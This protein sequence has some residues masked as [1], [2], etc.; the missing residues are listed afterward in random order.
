MLIRLVLVF[1][2]VLFPCGFLSLNAQEAFFDPTKDLLIAQFDCK[3]DVDDLHTVAALATLLNHKEYKDIHYH[4]VAGAYGIQ[5]GLYVLPNALFQLAF[6]THWSDAHEDGNK[7]TQEVLSLVEAQLDSGGN[8]W[9]AEAGQSDFSAKWI[10]ALQ[11]LRP[12]L[13]TKQRIHIVQHSKWNEEVTAP[14]SFEYVNR[15][16]DYRKIPDGNA[17]GNGT[18]GFRSDEIIDWRRQISTPN[19][20]Q[21]WEMALRIGQEY[22]GKDG[23]YLNTA[24]ANGGLDFSDLSETCYLLQ[25]DHL[26]DAVAFFAYFA[27]K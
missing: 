14:E 17:V 26:K 27:D 21:I 7:A 16:T 10:R 24:I 5:E 3:T 20:V 1:L 13:N 22:N 19:L 12:Q 15:V 9:V 8:I 25:L 4:A 2:Y 6:G 23:R 11:A 18:P